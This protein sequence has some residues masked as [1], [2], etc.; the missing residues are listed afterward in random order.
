MDLVANDGKR[1]RFRDPILRLWVRLYCHPVPP[2]DEAVAREVQRYALVRLPP[3]ESG[4]AS[5]AAK[6]GFP[7]PPVRAAGRT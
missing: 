7:A 2:T 3:R 1:Y 6:V 5:T 4:A